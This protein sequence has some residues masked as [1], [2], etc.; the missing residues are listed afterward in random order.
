M[1]QLPG[2]TEGAIK[3]NGPVG[4]GCFSEGFRSS[5][6]ARG[7]TAPDTAAS[8]KLSLTRTPDGISVTTTGIEAFI[9]DRNASRATVQLVLEL[10]T[11]T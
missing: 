8:A 11:A 10:A 7:S 5:A 3:P 6:P 9:R 4:Q 1:G 2:A